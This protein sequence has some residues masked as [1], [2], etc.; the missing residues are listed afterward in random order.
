AGVEANDSRVRQP[1]P[2]NPAVGEARQLEVV[3]VARAARHLVRAVPLRGV[4]ADDGERLRHRQSFTASWCSPK[5]RFMACAISPRVAYALTASTIGT[6]RFWH[7]RASS[8]SRSSAAFTN[9]L[10]RCAR[11]RASFDTWASVARGS[12]EESAPARWAST[13][14]SPTCQLTATFGISPDTIRCS[15]RY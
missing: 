9:P 11:T 2:E 3:E 14:R 4:L 7:P 13:G 12:S 10:S 15:Y 5:T 8:A 1:G 6:M